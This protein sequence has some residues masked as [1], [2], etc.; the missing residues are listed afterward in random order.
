MKYIFVGERPSP[1]AVSLGITWKDG[2]LAGKQLFDALAANN[3]DSS[4]QRFDNI[5]VSVCTGP[6]TVCYKAIRRI[7]KASK[8]RKVIAMGK[9]AEKVLTRYGIPCIMIIHPAA[10]GRI[11]KKERYIA[12][13]KEKLF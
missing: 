13:V 1:R 8:Q 7:R 3:I 6:E 9:K 11:R 2:G 10:R 5:F 12:H 4:Q